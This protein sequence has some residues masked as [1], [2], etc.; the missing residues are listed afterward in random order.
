MSTSDTAPSR[1]AIFAGART[2]GA[3]DPTATICVTTYARDFSPMRIAPL[4]ADD[5]FGG[6][7]AVSASVVDEQAPERQSAA[8]TQYDS[9]RG[10]FGC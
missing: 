2:S 10:T 9:N 6:E 7:N 4:P 5:E 1:N 8:P 3:V